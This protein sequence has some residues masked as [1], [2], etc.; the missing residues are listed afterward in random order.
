MVNLEQRLHYMFV[1]RLKSADP[2]RTVRRAGGSS[3]RKYFRDLLKML[4]LKHSPL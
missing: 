1:P 4:Y 3:L 2:R